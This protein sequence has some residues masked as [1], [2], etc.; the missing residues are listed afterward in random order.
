MA[1][2]PWQ[3]QP[4]GRGMSSLCGNLFSQFV[5]IYPA[6]RFFF[7]LLGKSLLFRTECL[8]FHIIAACSTNGSLALGEL[9][10]QG[11]EVVVD[12]FKFPLFV[13]GEFQLLRFCFRCRGRERTFFRP[14]LLGRGGALGGV[15]RQVARIAVY[16]AA[17]TDFKNLFGKFVEKIAV[18]RYSDYCALKRLQVIF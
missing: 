12:G 1:R 3:R 17:G 15:V 16:C 5:E 18:V 11:G 14:A 7:Q 4:T 8:E 2:V 10:F 6:G 13:V 9:F